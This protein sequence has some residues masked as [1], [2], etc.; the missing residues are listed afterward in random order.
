M[1]DARQWDVFCKVVDNWG[2][3]GVCWRLCAD[4]ADRSQ[5]LRLWVDHPGALAWMAPAGHAGVQVCAWNAASAAELAGLPRADVLVEAFGCPLDD[6]L[7][8]HFALHPPAWINLEYLSAEHYVRRHHGL[9][10]P[11][12]SGPGKGMRKHFF[13]PGFTAGTGGLLR[14][15]GLAQRQREFDRGS[16]LRQW[17]VAPGAARLVSLFCYEPPA[18]S[19]LL[20]QLAHDERPTA[21]LVTAGRAAQ[22]LNQALAAVGAASCGP[23]GHRQWGRLSIRELPL[24]SQ[25]EY[26]HLLWACDLN[27]VRGEDSLVRALWAGKPFV[28]NIYAQDDDAHHGKL[29]AFLDEL[30]VP[31]SLGQAYRAWNGVGTAVW[32]ALE[33][34]TWRDWETWARAAR[35]KAL[36][37]DDLVARLFE[38]LEKSG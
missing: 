29:E 16:W 36:A 37:Q 34:I 25:V 19:A 21:L 20:A 13:Y 35:E 18:L 15:P 24:L 14:E 5:K 27:F 11:V 22:A 9:L 6:K 23:D 2:D 38:F 7:V 10:S 28:W 33:H 12:L 8:R 31:P 30:A 3:L 17:D 26:D 4:L 1:A 32:P